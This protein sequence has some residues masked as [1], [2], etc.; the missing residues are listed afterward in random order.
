LRERP[1]R[2]GT[3][4]FAYRN[5]Q[6]GSRRSQ[7]PRRL[8]AVLLAAG[9]LLFGLLFRQR[10]GE[11][12]DRVQE[13]VE[14]YE[15]NPQRLIGPITEIGLN[16][17]GILAALLLIL[18]TAYY[19]AVRPEPLVDGLVS[20]FPPRRRDHVRHVL[21]RLRKSWVG[22][23]EGVAIDMLITFVL[24][25]VGLTI[26]G[27]D[28]AIFFAVLSALLVVVPYFG[29]IAG[30]AAKSSCRQA[31]LV[32]A[33]TAPISTKTTIR[34]W[35]TIQRRGCSTAAPL[36]DDGL[37]QRDGHGVHP[38]VSLEL[39]D[40]ALGVRLDRL[41][42]EAD[43]LRDLLGVEAL[44]QQLKDLALALGERGVRADL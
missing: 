26:I 36:L 8:P 6:G 4:R 44:G 30:D 24:L 29:A 5:R 20:L 14:R 17:A 13:F 9:L 41:G 31:S 1:A 15:E 12:G 27:L 37:P 32:I 11:I 10:A 23:M 22:W 28:F 39:E 35:T 25:W 19:M 7:L 21:D 33:M 2:P 42:G 43:A 34:T 38:R 3:R 40:G 18:I 16:V